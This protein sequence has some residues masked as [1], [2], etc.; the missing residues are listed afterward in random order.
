MSLSWGPAWSGQSLGCP[1]FCV[2]TG[3]L[4][5]ALLGGC[6]PDCITHLLSV[7]LLLRV[8]EDTGHINHTAAPCRFRASHL[9]LGMEYELIGTMM[10][11]ACFN[12]HIIE[13]QFPPVVFK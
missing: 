3:S 2:L 6:L 1:C 9:S 11:L 4:S 5:S 8:T 7:D 12:H 13:V 10:G